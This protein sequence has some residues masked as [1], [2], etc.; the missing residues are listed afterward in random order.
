RM[1]ALSEEQLHQ[2]LKIKEKQSHKLLGQILIA[3]GLCSREQVSRAI[4]QQQEETRLGSV[5][6]R[7]EILSATQLEE[8]LKEQQRT[9]RL[10]GFILVEK[11]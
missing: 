10:L 1:S 4:E 6:L 3:E 9:G 2:A 7:S 11:G 5:L 8:A